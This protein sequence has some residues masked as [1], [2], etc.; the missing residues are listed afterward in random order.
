M[1]ELK[2]VIFSIKDFYNSA[3]NKQ[4]IEKDSDFC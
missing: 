4:S 1:K 2:F 3:T